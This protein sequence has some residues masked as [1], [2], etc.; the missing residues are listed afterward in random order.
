MS[1]AFTKEDDLDREIELDDEGPKIPAG[2]KNYMTPAGAKRLQEELRD[3]RVRERPEITQTVAWAAGNGDRSENGDYLYGKKRLREIDRRIRFL[4]KRLESAEI[5]DPAAV[6]SD[7]V[8][9]GAT[10]TVS[11]E[12]GIEKIYSIVGID[13]IDA[14]KGLISWASPLATALFKSRIGD[15]VIFRS[16]RGIRELEVLEIR[17]DPINVSSEDPKP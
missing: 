11:D 14:S 12:E 15:V 10:V 13:E 8:L 6:K 1:K 4:T 7:Q 2:G 3:L 9:F 5:V 16:P 17:Y